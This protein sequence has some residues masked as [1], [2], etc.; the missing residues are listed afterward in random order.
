MCLQTSSGTM[1]VV[2][3]VFRR[4]ASPPMKPKLTS[5]TVI[6]PNW[7]KGHGGQRGSLP[8][9]N[10]VQWSG[11]SNL[12]TSPAH[13]LSSAGSSS[14]ASKRK[15]HL[16]WHQMWCAVWWAT[17]RYCKWLQLDKV[18][19]FIKETSHVHGRKHLGSRRRIIEGEIV[20]RTSS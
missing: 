2:A 3:A 16:C 20:F 14:T 11:F 19:V 7:T 1:K 6:L 18:E 9:S 8:S 13:F 17:K 4:S 15:H 12:C 10:I 5:K